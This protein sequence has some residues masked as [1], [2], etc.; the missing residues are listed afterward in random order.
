MLWV[1]LEGLVRKVIGED[2]GFNQPE[3]RFDAKSCAVISAIGKQ[4]DDI[5]IGVDKS[6]GR[7]SQGAGDQGLMFGFACN[8]SP[9]LIPAPIYYAHKLMIQHKKLRLI[10]LLIGFI[11]ML[12]AK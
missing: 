3:M 7:E 12:K 6:S 9:T 2:I 1:D 8:E 4:S 11:Q 10:L 5:S